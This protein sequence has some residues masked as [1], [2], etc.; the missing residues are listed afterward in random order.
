MHAPP[1]FD[2]DPA[3]P[4]QPTDCVVLRAA[5]AN[6]YTYVGV[7]T[8][9]GATLTECIR[10][11]RGVPEYDIMSLHSEA[12]RLLHDANFYR[13]RMSPNVAQNSLRKRVYLSEPR[14]KAVPRE[15]FYVPFKDV[16]AAMIRAPPGGMEQYEVVSAG[17]SGKVRVACTK[18]YCAMKSLFV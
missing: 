7:G 1:G 8:G 14:F 17:G 3:S 15:F 13:N 16:L 6:Y 5:S 12:V 2:I 10:L 18:S 9:Y 11:Y 4:A